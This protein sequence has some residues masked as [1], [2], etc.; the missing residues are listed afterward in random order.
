MTKFLGIQLYEKTKLLKRGE[1]VVLMLSYRCNLSCPHCLIHLP[2]GGRAELE[3]EGIEYWKH[4][5]GLLPIRVREFYVSGGELTYTTPWIAEFVRWLLNKGYHVTLCTNL[6]RV[7]PI[8][9][10]PNAHNFQISSTYHEQDD[11]EGFDKKFKLLRSL[12]YRIEAK[13]LAPYWQIQD[14]TAKKV[15]PY[16]TLEPIR[17][18][19][20]LYF[21]KRMFHVG[22]K[23][24]MWIGEYEMSLATTPK[25][26]V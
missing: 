4:V 1:S 10:I 2:G 14:G 26:K 9:D 7:G 19:Q 5:V 3:E 12:G 11:A 8:M 25:V 21:D 18:A 22:P 20:R 23:Y 16:S 17:D 15:L 6:Y 24:R 13:E